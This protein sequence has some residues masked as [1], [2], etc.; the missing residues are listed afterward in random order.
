MTL[1][2]LL[3]RRSVRRYADAPVPRTVVDA[4]LPRLLQQTEKWWA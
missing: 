1:Q 2:D 4:A 3:A